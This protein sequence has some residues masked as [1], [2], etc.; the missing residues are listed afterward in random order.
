MRDV[1]ARPQND[2]VTPTQS[3]VAEGLGGQVEEAAASC[4]EQQSVR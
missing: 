1:T 4:T 3:G 2:L